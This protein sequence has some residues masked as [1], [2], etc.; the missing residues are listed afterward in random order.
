MQLSFGIMAPAGYEQK[1]KNEV[2]WTRIAE[3]LH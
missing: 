2:F 3:S 1:K